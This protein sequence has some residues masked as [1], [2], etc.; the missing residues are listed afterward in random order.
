M[1]AGIGEKTGG[2][3][4]K[5][6]FLPVGLPLFLFLPGGINGGMKGAEEGKKGFRGHCGG[7]NSAFVK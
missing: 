1:G 4:G 3:K 7:G 2:E 5:V 6:P